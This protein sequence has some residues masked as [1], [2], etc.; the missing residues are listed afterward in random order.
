MKGV[1]PMSMV[2]HSSWSLICGIRHRLHLSTKRKMRDIGG[3]LEFS[4]LKIGPKGAILVTMIADFGNTLAEWSVPALV[5]LDHLLHHE[6]SVLLL[7]HLELLVLN[8][9]L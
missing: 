9:L 1:R 4:E 6:L 3:P 2:I 7:Q 5:H 8:V